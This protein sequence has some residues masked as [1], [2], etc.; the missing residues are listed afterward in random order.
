M[1]RSCR[2]PR[3]IHGLLER[4]VLPVVTIFWIN[5]VLKEAPS[6]IDK[7]FI[8]STSRMTKSFFLSSKH[9]TYRSVVHPFVQT[10]VAIR[11]NGLAGG[12]SRQDRRLQTVYARGEGPW[13]RD[14]AINSP[15]RR[16]TEEKLHSPK[17]RRRIENHRM[18]LLDC[19]L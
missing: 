5:K 7:I 9:K 10:C 15:E 12:R 13:R 6:I 3:Q 17:L 18:I 2:N 1:H 4:N 14:R 19:P 8:L 11:P 16:H